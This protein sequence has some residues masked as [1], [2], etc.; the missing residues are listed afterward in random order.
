[1]LSVRYGNTLTIALVALPVLSI[2]AMMSSTNHFLFWIEFVI[3]VVTGV[4]VLFCL[5]PAYWRSH[6]HAFLYLAFAFMVGIFDCVADHTIAL[7][8]MPHRQYLAYVILRRLARLAGF[9]LLAVGVIGL[10]RSDFAEAARTDDTT[11]N[12]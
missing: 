11:P 1:M 5:F 6:N 4:S 12:A 7:W 2:S 10:T 9:I 3:V 8:H